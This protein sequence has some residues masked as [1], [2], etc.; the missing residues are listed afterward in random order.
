GR[1]MSQATVDSI[2]QGRVWTG[3]DALKINLVDELGGLDDALAYV[4]K[5]ASLKEYKTV[6]LPKQKN[7]FDDFFGK[8]QS[9]FESKLMKNQLGSM[10]VY[11]RQVQNMLDMEGIQARL[12]FG[13]M[14]E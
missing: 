11:C 7:P 14:F 5:K 10:C 8:K 13:M 9:E 12:P 4:A 3:A 1:G 6:E 2:G